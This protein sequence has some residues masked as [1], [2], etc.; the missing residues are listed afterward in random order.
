MICPTLWSYHGLLKMLNQIL[1]KRLISAATASVLLA[2][3]LAATGA[4][5]ECRCDRGH[6][7]QTLGPGHGHGWCE[8]HRDDVPCDDSLVVLDQTTR[9]DQPLD[10]AAAAVQWFGP[11]V[12]HPGDVSDRSIL[13]LPQT[14]G[15]P[16][17]LRAVVR[18]TVLRT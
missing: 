8:D 2:V 16:E 17:V 18:S 3:G 4:V 5:I 1:S 10:G 9:P 14:G 11:T 13:R 6:V 7:S 15:P 12:S